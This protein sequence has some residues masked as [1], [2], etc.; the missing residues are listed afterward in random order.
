MKLSEINI[1]PIKSLAGIRLES[2]RVE[3]RGLEFDRRWMLVDD[4][5]TFLTQRE[6]PVMAT[7]KVTVD[8]RMLTASAGWKQIEI[9]FSEDN[10]K[11]TT[12]KIW[13]S[14]VKAEVYDDAINEW[15]SEA[16]GTKCSLV[17]MTPSSKRIVSPFYAVRR[18][19]DQ[20]SFADGYPFLLIGEA[21]LADLNSRL[22]EP[23]PMNRFRPSFVV[24]GSEPFAEDKWKKIRIGKTLYHVVKQCERCVITTIDQTEGEKT[25]KEPL[26]TL[27]GFRNQKGKILF[28]QNLIADEP[29]GTISIGEAVEIV[30]SR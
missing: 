8:G 1:Y 26:A 23:L 19:R 24:K 4:S 12:V 10:G 3:A 28:G 25:G 21:S 16:L 27:S 29:E 15:F 22:P 7:I 6:F 5:R 18:F 14:S 9:P 13:N 2:A 17:A 11:K 20:V 30:E